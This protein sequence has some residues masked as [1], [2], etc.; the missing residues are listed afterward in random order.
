MSRARIGHL[1]TVGKGH[2]LLAE[3]QFQLDEC[4][5]VQQFVAQALQLVAVA[6]SHLIH[7][8]MVGR[9]GLRLDD[10]GDRLG[11]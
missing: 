8:H 2:I 10:V 1:A 9:T 7:R 5:K 6:A 11:L 4:S 3:V